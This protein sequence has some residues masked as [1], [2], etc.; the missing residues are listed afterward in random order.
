MGQSKRQKV[1]NKNG[2]CN[3]WAPCRP[4]EILRALG[5]DARHVF[6]IHVHSDL[7]PAVLPSR[8]Y[9]AGS[10]AALYS[11]FSVHTEPASSTLSNFTDI[12]KIT[13]DDLEMILEGLFGGAEYFPIAK[14][15]VRS[16]HQNKVPD[17][18]LRGND[19]N[20]RLGHG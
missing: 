18:E 11:L 14:P 19:I 1:D 8:I 13:L 10:V 6:I 3:D 17:S 7:P 2:F 12:L 15:A 5:A 9:R 20:C 4:V 16:S